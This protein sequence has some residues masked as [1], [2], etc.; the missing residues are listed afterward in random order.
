MKKNTLFLPIIIF[1]LSFAT[2]VIAQS[3]T[4]DSAIKTRLYRDVSL[5]ASDSLDGR[6]AGKK[7]EQMAC[8]YISEKMRKIGLLPKGDQEGSYLSEFKMNYPVLFRNAKLSVNDIDFKYYEEFGATD[9][10]STG[11]LTAPL[12]DIGKGIAGIDYDTI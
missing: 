2:S 8:S 9:F 3:V 11:N 6:E 5:L 12:L 7:G 10:S 4:E 1:S